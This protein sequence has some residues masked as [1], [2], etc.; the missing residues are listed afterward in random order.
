MVATIE[1]EVPF[2]EMFGYSTDIRSVTQ[3]KGEFSM[4][5]LK[6]QAVPR[7]VQEELIAKYKE[8]REGS[9]GEEIVR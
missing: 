9:S 2:S 1:A 6:Y 7:N 4:E 5:F 8:Q 3:G